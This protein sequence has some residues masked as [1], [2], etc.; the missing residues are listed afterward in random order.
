MKIE[1]DK[2]P[3]EMDFLKIINVDKETDP[4]TFS[5]IWETY[6]SDLSREGMLSF[7]IARS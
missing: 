5:M 1:K 2:D 4:K 7:K 3:K 6:S